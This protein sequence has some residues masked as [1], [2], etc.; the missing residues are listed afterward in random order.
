MYFFTSRQHGCVRCV[1]GLSSSY[2]VAAAGLVEVL[3]CGSGLFFPPRGRAR[4]LRPVAA[5]QAVVV[6]EATVATEAAKPK[7]IAVA[8]VPTTETAT[9]HDSAIGKMS[10]HVAGELQGVKQR[11]FIPIKA[12]ISKEM[13]MVISRELTHIGSSWRARQSNRSPLSPVGAW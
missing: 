7:N 4:L 5:I 10:A 9:G 6:V 1:D 12:A 8:T 2:V 3:E 13:H 11:R